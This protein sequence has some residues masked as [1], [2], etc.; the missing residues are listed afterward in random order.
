MRSR[1]EDVYLTFNYDTGMLNEFVSKNTHR[2]SIAQKEN[3]MIRSV[4]VS[5]ID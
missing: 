3:K 2:D 4:F 5:L 1:G